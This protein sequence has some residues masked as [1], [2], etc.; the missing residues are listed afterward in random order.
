MTWPK[1]FYIA[2]AMIVSLA[3]FPAR[4]AAEELSEVTIDGI[5][6]VVD[7]EKAVVESAERTITEANILERVTVGGKEYRVSSIA[8]MA[9]YNCN[10]MTSVTIPPS[11]TVIGSL[12][13]YKCTSLNSVHISDLKAWCNIDFKI[14]S[15]EYNSLSPST[16]PLYYASRFILNGEEVTQLVIPN[17]V[18]SI[19]KYAFYGLDSLTMLVLPESM[20]QIMDAAFANCPNIS[21][22]VSWNSTP[23]TIEWSTFDSTTTE[24]AE[25]LLSGYDARLEYAYAIGWMSFRHVGIAVNEVTIDGIT[26]GADG[27]GAY[28]KEADDM[29]TTA[30]IKS[31]VKILGV[32]YTVN[33]IRESAFRLC[34]NLSSVTIPESVVTIGDYAFFCC[35]SMKTVDMPSAVTSMGEGAF[36]GC[37]SLTSLD[38]PKSITVIAEGT[39]LSCHSLKDVTIPA[40]VTAIGDNAFHGC[41]SLTSVVIPDGVTS[42]GRSTFHFCEGLTS[43][44]IPNSVT[45]IGK[46][47]FHCCKAL[48]EVVIPNSVTTIGDYAFYHCNSLT[49]VIIPSSVTT[50]GEAAFEYCTGLTMVALPESVSQIGTAAFGGCEDI[51]MIVSQNAVPP[52]LGEKVFDSAV[53]RN[54]LLLV[55]SISI[56]AYQEA[57]GWKNFMNISENP[58]L[59]S[60]IDNIKGDS[61]NGDDMEVF[62]LD[63]KRIYSGSRYERQLA[64]G[65]YIVRQ[66]KTTAKLLVR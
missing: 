22:I 31:D 17:G 11:I 21:R 61:L 3:L 46:S 66:G 55:P 49:S 6:Y 27:D 25:L 37:E 13:F 34:R 30:D 41:K 62:T 53:E 56:V 45:S 33:S 47:A 48:E 2:A 35:E 15:V 5:T 19:G 14:V 43:V 9:F 36:T 42:I 52:I 32:E 58:G 7:G 10:S 23:P 16:S 65:I 29:I 54:A 18:T 38:I 59:D 50:I 57:D 63:G 64:P 1:C 20:T 44:E 4:I 26:Y 40:S 12:A 60:G 8:G 39:F 24:N 28:V 51:S